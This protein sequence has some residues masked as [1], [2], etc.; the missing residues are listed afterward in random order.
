MYLKYQK[1]IYNINNYYSII[2]NGDSSIHLVKKDENY[3]ALSFL[4]KEMRD[5]VL[6]SIWLNIED[7]AFDVDECIKKFSETHKYNL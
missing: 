5:H 4:N 3:S 7:E 1:N 2:K 6:D